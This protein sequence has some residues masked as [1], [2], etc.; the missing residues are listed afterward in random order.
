MIKA[1]VCFLPGAWNEIASAELASIRLDWAATKP[2]TVEWAIVLRA[3]WNTLLLA[4]TS[5]L[6]SVALGVPVAACAAY[7][8]RGFAKNPITALFRVTLSL[9]FA[10]PT[11]ALAPFLIQALGLRWPHLPIVANN[12]APSEIWAMALPTITL[13]LGTSA[14]LTQ[15][16]FE[17]LL[18]KQGVPYF[19][20]A[21]AKGLSVWRAIWVHALPNSLSTARAFLLFKLPWLLSGASVVELLFQRG[22]LGLLAYQALHSR[23][24]DLLYALLTVSCCAHFAAHVLDDA[25]N[26]FWPPAAKERS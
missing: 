7:W 24:T 11:I 13:S 2:P 22:G 18:E 4:L 20:T 6:V 3:F 17:S 25:I 8:L 10:F 12:D 21:L 14:V 5:V 19:A 9:A 15:L 16:I 1:L 26:E 23:N